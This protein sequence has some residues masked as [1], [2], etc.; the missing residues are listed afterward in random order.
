M[1][2]LYEVTVQRLAARSVDLKV[3]PT[4]PDC[5]PFYLTRLFVLALLRDAPPKKVITRSPLRRAEL[6]ARAW[7]GKALRNRRIYDSSI[8]R[9][10]FEAEHALVASM[11]E[12]DAGDL[13]SSDID[14]AEYI[15]EVQV[16]KV[17]TARWDHA[18]ANPEA[19]YRVTVTEGRWLAHITESSVWDST[20]YDDRKAVVAPILNLTEDMSRGP[21]LDGS[22]AAVL[23]EAY[24]AHF[25]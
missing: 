3:V 1:G 19:V 18:Q 15:E 2:A 5:C 4:Q 10:F 12:R 22:A 23:D 11:S 24:L 20:A 7:V 17:S 9:S 8:Q 13:G 25:R 6:L 21:V 16:L 14:S